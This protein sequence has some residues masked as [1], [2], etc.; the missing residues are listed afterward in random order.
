MKYRGIPTNIITG[1][2]GAGK[3]T[4]ILH[5]LA[6][7]PASERWAVLVNEFGEIGIDGALLKNAGAEVREVPGG[8]MCC[9]A[10]LPMQI[11]LNRLI[12]S[13]KPD[14]LIIEPTG[15]GHPAEI[16][17]V[18]TS[19]PYAA[20][21]KIQASITL[22]DPRKLSD[23]RYVDNENF[24]A[25]AALADVLVANKIDVATAEERHAFN[26]Y[27]QAFAPRKSIV[28]EVTQG[29]ID[30]AWLTLPR[31][32]RL[33]KAGAAHTASSSNAL[34]NT[35]MTQL[36]PAPGE[37][38]RR[39]ENRGQ[40]FFSCGWVF[41]PEVVFAMD[42]LFIWLSG[43]FCRRVKGVMRTADAIMA[44]NAENGVL[45]I[46]ELDDA[47]DSRLEIIHDELLDWQAIE[48]ILLASRV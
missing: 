36:G 43:L 47:M 46:N 9:V 44:F 28:A 5:L 7:K 17:R 29:A 10:G 25:Q 14:R 30:P 35:F 37:L 26:R 1:F 38:F 19:P 13:A 4:A 8:C 48:Q 42:K 40:G 34:Q 15:L 23:P 18:L 11:G 41:A 24:A 32:D 45:S 21:L 27:A 22:I 3:T 20:L 2:L 31:R 6:Q 16:L 39:Q 12:S 33:L